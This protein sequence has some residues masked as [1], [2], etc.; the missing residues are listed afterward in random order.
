MGVRD[1]EEADIART[2]LTLNGDDIDGLLLV[3]GRT[4]VARGRVVSD[5]GSPLRVTNMTVAT[6]PPTPAERLGLMPSVRVKEDLTFELKGLYGPLLFNAYP[7][8]HQAPGTPPW[9]LKSVM[10]NNVDIIDKPLDFQPGMVVDGLELVFT[11]KAA[12]L[13]GTLTIAGGA[14]LADAWVLL[15]PGDETLWR[16]RSRLMRAAR[17]EKDGS[18]RFRMVPAHHDYLLVT[19]LHLEPGQHMDPDFL[20][21][22]R[23]E[24]LRISLAD[25]EKKLQNIRISAM[26]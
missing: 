23:D 2:T 11:Q 16:D 19:A 8:P 22:V 20:R 10:L 4:G 14:S 18:Y 5:D 12:E 9:M 6:N 17:P 3:A 26:R 21:S 7:A 13:S 24:A 15:F 25:G 1:D